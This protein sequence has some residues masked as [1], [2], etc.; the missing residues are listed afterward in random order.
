MMNREQFIRQLDELLKKLRDDER[1]DILQDFEE[2]FDIGLEQGKTEE[3]IAASLGSPQ[4]IA[5][6]LLAEHY[7]NQA[8][9]TFSASNIIKA[10]WA[11]LS[12]GFFN[13]AIVFGPFLALVALVISGWLAGLLFIVAPIP[14]LI[15]LV[16]YPAAFQLFDLFFSIML[17]G[18]GIL[19]L[20]GMV[21]VSRM[22]FKGFIKYLRFNIKLVKGGLEHD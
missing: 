1:R 7:V 11:T 21:Y 15:N 19:I 17:T 14:V 9:V 13:F 8:D 22:L 16:L 20:I 18:L 12:L 3:E 4:Q 5:K 10:A 2:H 6:E